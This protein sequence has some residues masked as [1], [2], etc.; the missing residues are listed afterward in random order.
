MFRSPEGIAASAPLPAARHIGIVLADFS[1][2]GTERVALRLAQ[3]WAGAGRRVTLYCGDEEGPS[4][5]LVGPGIEVRPAMPR[6]SRPLSR[7]ALGRLLAQMVAG[8]P[9]DAIFCPGN[10]HVPILS[11][12]RASLGR[13]CPPIVAKISNPIARPH[14]SWL[15][16]RLFVASYRWRTAGFE[17]LVAMSP[18]LA[19][20][21]A[22]ALGRRAIPA[23]AEPTLDD[24][25]AL[26]PPRAP[27]SL[28]LAIGRL[29]P[30]KNLALALETLALTRRDRRLLIL[31]EGD[32]YGALAD[33]AAAL[34]LGDRVRFA[35]YVADVRP[36]LAIA[37]VLLCSSRYEG[38]PAALIEALAAR[39]PVVSTNC[40]PAL[41]EIIVDPS[42]GAI[43][44]ADP[45]ALAEALEAVIDECRRPDEAL[46][47]PLLQ[48]HRAE[49]SGLAWLALLDEAVAARS[50]AESPRPELAT[51][52]GLVPA[53]RPAPAG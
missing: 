14:R 41:P 34:G 27:G 46:L 30:Q 28:I 45:R 24:D 16:Q 29:T 40:S 6:E 11:A 51:I 3:V 36:Y 19:T 23:L 42:F 17:R 44:P 13:R 48:R 15:S 31:G 52:A 43:V 35:G 9:P 10:H 49:A 32:D 18:A 7:G 47:A 26:P 1:S 2:G 33:R 38:Y 5:D 37:D 50:H 4:R 53:V 20:E 39:V 25:A 22:R 21:A 12:I 8:S